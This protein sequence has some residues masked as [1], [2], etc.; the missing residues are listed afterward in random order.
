MSILNKN[1]ILI[2]GFLLSLWVCYAIAI[3]P[4]IK[5]K[6]E[7]DALKKR[8]L[9]NE[10][11]LNNLNLLLFQKKQYDQLLD[12]Y[13]LNSET[14]LQNNLLEVLNKF[15]KESKVTIVSFN[16]PH[17]FKSKNTKFKTYS[18]KLKGNFTSILKI[19]HQLE[20]EYSFGKITS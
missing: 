3:S 7:V 17:T 4:T 13:N 8:H 10:Q 6:T 15:G 12:K 18:F 19:I 20:Q 11:T 5:L 2:I 1:S 14:S 16:Q 9:E